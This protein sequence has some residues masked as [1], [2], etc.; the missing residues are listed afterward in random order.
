MPNSVTVWL[1][2]FY[3]YV[4]LAAI[5]FKL[6]Q[7]LTTLEMIKLIYIGEEPSQFSVSC[8]PEI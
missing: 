4:N 7:V 3:S 8:F 5:S 6:E 2:R 1:D